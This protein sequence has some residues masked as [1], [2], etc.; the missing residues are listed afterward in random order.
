MQK[1]M[2][3]MFVSTCWSSIPSLF[4]WL[5][6]CRRGSSR[7]PH[8]LCLPYLESDHCPSEIQNI[9]PLDM[10]ENTYTDETTKHT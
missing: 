6:L 5:R 8:K 4:G 10:A 1:N 7:Q 3:I 2:F 9:D